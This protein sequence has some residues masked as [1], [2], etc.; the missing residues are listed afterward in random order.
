MSITN[1]LYWLI[2]T[3]TGPPIKDT[4]QMIFSDALKAFVGLGVSIIITFGRPILEKMIS[5]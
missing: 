1:H 2:T 4:S 5:K 3:Y